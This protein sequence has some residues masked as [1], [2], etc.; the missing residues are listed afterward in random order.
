M[1]TL[2]Q[3]LSDGFA[4]L[5]TKLGEVQGHAAAWQRVRVAHGPVVYVQEARLGAW[6]IRRIDAVGTVSVATDAGSNAGLDAAQAWADR[7]ALAYT[8]A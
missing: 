1:T 2:V 3:A 6:R 4:A 8:D 5:A 7:A